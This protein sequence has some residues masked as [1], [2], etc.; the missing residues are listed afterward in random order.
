MTSTA[1][2]QSNPAPTPSAATSAPSYASAAG[3]NKKQ[4]STPLI[5]T[6]SNP[7]VVVGG[8]SAQNAKP[9]AP[10]P[11][12]GRPPITPAVPAAPA[13]AHGSSANNMNGS[14]PDHARKSSVTLSA[15]GPNSFAPNGGPVGGAK[16]GIQFG[17][18]SPAVAH[19]TPQA[20]A[21]PIPIPGSN[22][23]VPSPAHSPSP[24]PQPS[25]S[26]G[27]PPSGMAQPNAM[28]FG[29]L[30]SDGDVS[31][32]SPVLFGHR[33]CVRA[34]DFLIFFAAPHETSLYSPEPGRSSCDA[35]PAHPT[36]VRRFSAQ[37]RP[38][39]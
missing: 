8:S 19:S 17:Y 32:I 39:P 9:S 2:P 20:T 21:A 5:A 18:N 33:A 36:R 1:S 6:G 34:T 4:A 11:V 31:D 16:P 13:V 15:N 10:S 37:R 22:Q 26:G 35:R 28:T 29:S 23:R 14:A 24:I 12:N 25:A 3:A 7:P 30:G 27:R 38:W